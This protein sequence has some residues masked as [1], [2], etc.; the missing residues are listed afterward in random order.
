[1]R[2]PLIAASFLPLLLGCPARHPTATAP[3]GATAPTTEHVYRA[4]D[5]G[6]TP[7]KVAV[8]RAPDYTENARKAKYQ[9]IA[10]L[11][12]V[13]GTDGIA[14]DIKIIKSLKPDLDQK[15]MDSVLQWKFTPGKKDGRPVP[16]LVQIEVN[17]HLY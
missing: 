5:P 6:V 17:F 7:P 4:T 9:G 11:S 15:A 1:M 2:R 8:F 10:V 12:A 14:H 13:V 3:A 16:V